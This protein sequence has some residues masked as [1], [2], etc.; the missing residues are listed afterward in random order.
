MTSVCQKK[1][2]PTKYREAELNKGE[3]IC[4]D[5]CVAKYLEVHDQIGK[6]LTA[7][8]MQDD[9]ANKR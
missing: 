7:L 2:I 1:C 5:R 4:I 6:R 3:A 8:S 9:A